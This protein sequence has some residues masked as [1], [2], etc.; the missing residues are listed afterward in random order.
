LRDEGIEVLPV[1]RLRQGLDLV[2]GPRMASE[3]R[4]PAAGS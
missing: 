2:L 3:G 4:V 1:E